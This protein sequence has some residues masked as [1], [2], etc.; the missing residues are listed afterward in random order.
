MQW[1]NFC[2]LRLCPMCTARR[3]L[4][5]AMKLSKVMTLTESRYG[6]QYLFLTL[7]VENCEGDKL[8]ETLSL[9]TKSWDRLIRQRPVAAA[10]KGWYRA[11]EITH[12]KE[13]G[14]HPHIHAIL[15]VGADYRPRSKQY[16][17]QA[18]W[19]RRWQMALKVSYKPIVDIR[20]TKEGK[21]GLGAVLEAAK[22][23][24]KDSDYIDPKLSEEEGAKILTDYT[25]ALHGRRLVAFGGVMKEIAAQLGADKEDTDLIHVDDDII[26]DDLAD[27]IADYGW[28]FG[29]GDYIL[30]DRRVN[31][32][33][34]V[35][36]GE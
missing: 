25:R 10:V 32:L 36:K 8:G 1:A 31:P 4:K 9:L 16:I 27:M 7:T 26:R 19:V 6:V 22:Y 18:E 35:K 23:T 17:T 14:Y 21:G 24:T 28:H 12:G 2:H 30:T 15:A 34:V 13:T 11:I 33:K 5:N 29:A 3:A 20:K